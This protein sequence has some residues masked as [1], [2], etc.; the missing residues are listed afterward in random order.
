MK[1]LL[2]FS[3]AVLVVGLSQCAKRQDDFEWSAYKAEHGKSYQNVKEDISR[4]SI[5]MKS[6]KK[7]EEHNKKF[8]LGLTT[9]KKAINEFSDLKPQEMGTFYGFKM[10]KTNQTRK[11]TKPRRRKILS[12]EIDW[13]DQGAVTDV[14]NQ[15]QCGSCY[16]FSVTGAIE[17]QLYLSSN[18]LISLSEQ[19]IM[20]CTGRGCNGGSMMQSFDYIQEQG[21]I[22]SE[23]D[24]PYV[25][26]NGGSCE[27]DYSR[28]KATISGYTQIDQDEYSLQ[29]AVAERGPVSFGMSVVDS[30]R[31]YSSGVYDEY[32]CNSKSGHAMLIVG[33]GT[34]PDYGEY[35]LV[36][37]SWVS[38]DFLFMITNDLK[39]LFHREQTGAKTGIYEWPEES[40]FAIS[41]AELLFQM[42]LIFN[43][44]KKILKL[45][46]LASA[47]FLSH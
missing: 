26:Q 2:V 32:N 8:D 30:F 13:R 11:T 36:K 43:H 15:G 40:T 12:E 38:E 39:F 5:W 3:V 33:Y 9:Y 41:L 42:T 21:G 22:E 29:E 31:E 46:N 27:F 7:V 18:R 17:G 34:D 23:D 45:K 37:N 6:K 44:N 28:V 35:W 16:S 4:R 25:G 14:K 20:D 19:Q 47:R 10:G 24:Y 1:F